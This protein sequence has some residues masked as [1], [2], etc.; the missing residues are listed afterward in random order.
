MPHQYNRLQEVIL[1]PEKT[2]IL[3]KVVDKLAS[4]QAIVQ[5]RDDGEG[6]ISPLFLVPKSDGSWRPV[7][8][9]KLLDTFIAAQ[10]FKM[11]SIRTVK[12]LIQQ[13]DWLLKLDLKDAYLTVPIH[14]AHHK[15][16]RFRWEVHTWQFRTLSFGLSSAP[17]TFTK[18]MKP[19]VATLRRLGIRLTLYLDDMLLMAQSK[20]RARRSQTTML[21]L[22]TALGFIVNVKKSILCPRRNWS[23]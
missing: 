21:K 13:G 6:F 23:F 1:E 12:D 4:K 14:Y 5:V 8:N 7:I 15:F 2:R 22:L 10:H 18:L 19:V 11:E 3:A 17:L 16:L 9:L 20:A